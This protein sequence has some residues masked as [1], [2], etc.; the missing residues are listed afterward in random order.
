MSWGIAL[1]LMATT[2]M[3][4][5][6]SLN[7]FEKTPLDAALTTEPRPSDWAADSNQL[8]LFS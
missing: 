4:C 1:A 8:I 6:P 2:G 5:V 7:L 3:C